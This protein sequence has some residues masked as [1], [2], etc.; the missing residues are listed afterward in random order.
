MVQPQQTASPLVVNP[1]HTRLQK[2]VQKT[3][4][5]LDLFRRSVPVALV[6]NRNEP[7]TRFTLPRMTFDPLMIEPN[8]GWSVRSP[9]MPPPSFFLEEGAV[10]RVRE[11]CPQ[12]FYHGD[13]VA[14]RPSIRRSVL[15]DQ[16]LNNPAA[17][18]LRLAI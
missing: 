8:G 4:D 9:R 16:L 15:A 3:R 17:F 2:A 5:T 1:I 18:S 7:Q 14:R 6:T 12:A 11:R 10:N 13:K